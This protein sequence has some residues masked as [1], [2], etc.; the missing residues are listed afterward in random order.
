M[1]SAMIVACC[2]RG[3]C[4]GNFRGARSFLD[5]PCDGGTNDAVVAARNGRAWS[6][7]TISVDV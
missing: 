2:D 3:A 6:R 1:Q 5:A 4:A 7:A